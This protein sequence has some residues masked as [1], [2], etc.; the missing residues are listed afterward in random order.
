MI[1]S[2]S[3]SPPHFPL[4]LSSFPHFLLFFSPP[5]LHFSCSALLCL[6]SLLLSPVIPFLSLLAPSLIF[7]SILYCLSSLSSLHSPVSS[8]LYLVPISFL[9]FFYLRMDFFSVYLHVY[10]TECLLLL[11]FLFR[12]DTYIQRSCKDVGK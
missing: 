9:I 10:Y 7:S 8:H 1:L 3:F 5:L 12:F 6:L 4:L 2:A 11:M